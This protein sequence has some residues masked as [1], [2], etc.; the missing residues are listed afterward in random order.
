M[1]LTSFSQ[2]SVI[3]LSVF[4]P[5]TCKSVDGTFYP[6]LIPRLSVVGNLQ[7]RCV[8]PHKSTV[9]LRR[10]LNLKGHLSTILS[11]RRE[12]GSVRLLVMQI[13]W[14]AALLGLGE[15]WSRVATSEVCLSPGCFSKAYSQASEIR[16]VTHS[17][18]LRPGR[19]F[20]VKL[21]RGRGVEHLT[22]N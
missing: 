8:C 11:T 9:Y 7:P 20:R 3:D 2:R 14:V 10:S 5:H 4:E 13:C 19:G 22:R 1:P 21:T 17:F 6:V 16:Q 18:A 15:S 12:R